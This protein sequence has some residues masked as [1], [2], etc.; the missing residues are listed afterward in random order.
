MEKQS[1]ECSLAAGTFPEPTPTHDC[2][3]PQRT[4][5]QTNKNSEVTRQHAAPPPTPVYNDGY[6]VPR[7]TAQKEVCSKRLPPQCVKHSTSPISSVMPDVRS[8]HTETVS[9]LLS[10]PSHKEKGA[11]KENCLNKEQNQCLTADGTTTRLRRAL[12]V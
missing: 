10:S 1:S 4:N 2:A 12:S 11:E 3:F 9:F 6:V 7:T 8:E 5:K